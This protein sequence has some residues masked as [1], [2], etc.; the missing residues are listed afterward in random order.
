MNSTGQVLYESVH[1]K[2]DKLDIS[3]ETHEKRFLFLLGLKEE[4]RT[5]GMR[6]LAKK[7]GSHV[8]WQWQL[9]KVDVIDA[10]KEMREKTK[11]NLNESKGDKNKKMKKD[12]RDEKRLTALLK[13]ENSGHIEEIENYFLKHKSNM[14]D[15]IVQ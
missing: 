4:Y 7:V 10:K 6:D 12:K 1:E 8:H 5:K 14:N 15:R 11:R 3:D 9:S 13:V 2:D